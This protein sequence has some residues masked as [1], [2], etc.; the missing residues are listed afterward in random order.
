[1]DNKELDRRTI[2]EILESID[3]LDCKCHDLLKVESLFYPRFEA[4][5]CQCKVK[6]EG[7]EHEVLVPKVWITVPDHKVKGL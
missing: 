3:K 6:V 5:A 7:E 1:L 2:L 4:E